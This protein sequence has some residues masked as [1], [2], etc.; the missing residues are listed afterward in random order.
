M[1]ENTIKKVIGAALV[2]GSFAD[3]VLCELP[4]IVKPADDGSQGQ[5]WFGFN[6]AQSGWIGTIFDVI[7]IAGGIMLYKS[8]SNGKKRT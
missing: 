1:D 7:I 4:R 3:L 5:P 2:V 8:G 6:I